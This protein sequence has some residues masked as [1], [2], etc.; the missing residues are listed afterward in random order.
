MVGGAALWGAN[1]EDIF[2]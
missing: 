1:Y 2:T